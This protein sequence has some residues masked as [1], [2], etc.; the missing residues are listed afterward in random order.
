MGKDI[1]KRN[2]N[3]ILLLTLFRR[4]EGGGGQVIG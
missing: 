1:F 2:K 3:M 4:E